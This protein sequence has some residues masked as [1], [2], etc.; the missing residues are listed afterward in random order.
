MCT[1]PCLVL[2]RLDC[3]SV[4]LKRKRTPSIYGACSLAGCERSRGLCLS[5]VP[6]RDDLRLSDTITW[7][8]R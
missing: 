1:D 8:R 5:S 3:G 7:R 2:R 4:A 6:S